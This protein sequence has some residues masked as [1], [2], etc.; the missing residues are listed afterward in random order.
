MTKIQQIPRLYLP[1]AVLTMFGPLLIM[2]LQGA[3][4]AIYASARRHP[5]RA[6]RSPSLRSSRRVRGSWF[7]RLAVGD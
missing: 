5:A 1:F 7:G 4:L 2:L 6:G 3:A